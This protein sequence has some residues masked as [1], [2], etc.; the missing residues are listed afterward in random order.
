MQ[1]D[2][3]FLHKNY[4]TYS[5]YEKLDYYIRLFIFKVV[6]SNWI[7]HNLPMILFDSIWIGVNGNDSLKSKLQSKF[8]NI[9][10]SKSLFLDRLGIKSSF[11]CSIA[12][13]NKC[14]LFWTRSE[15]SSDVCWEFI[16]K[17]VDALCD[18]VSVCEKLAILFD[19]NS[20]FSDSDWAEHYNRKNIFIESN[21]MP[22]T[23]FVFV[24]CFSYT[25]EDDGK[26][27]RE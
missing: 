24:D 3:Y 2:Y 21:A 25:Y 12:R 9:I 7:Q 23:Y 1:H 15:V 6:C 10:C 18:V 13:F 27:V 16:S 17:A 19:D 11:S 22:P 20:I 26:L 14:C 5:S 8:G 4:L